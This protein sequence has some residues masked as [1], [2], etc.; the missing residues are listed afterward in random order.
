[1]LC[2]WNKQ[3]PL[4]GFISLT[5]DPREPAERLHISDNYE[6]GQTMDGA[7]QQQPVMPKMQPVDSSHIAQAGHDPAS[8]SLM[9]GFHNGDLYQYEDVPQGTYVS[10]LAA[11]SAGQFFNAQIKGRFKATKLRDHREKKAE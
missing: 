8:K 5:V 6:S 9:I 2:L 1:M 10:M 3:S 11:E 4:R 7:P